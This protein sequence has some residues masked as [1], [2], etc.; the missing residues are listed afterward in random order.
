MKSEEVTFDIDLL[1]ELLK[2]AETNDIMLG[3]DYPNAKTC[4]LW[5]LPQY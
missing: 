5:G 4:E 3:V 1:E 2:S